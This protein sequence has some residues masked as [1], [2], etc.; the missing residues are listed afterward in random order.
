M[1]RENSKNGIRE[2]LLDD[3]SK[4]YEARVHRR[5]EPA[6]SKRFKT[7]AEAL[8]W[9]RSVDTSI[10]VGRPTLDRKV[11]LIRDVI[12]DYLRYRASSLK[13]LASNKV[14][15]YL[16]VREDL[17][18]ISVSKLTHIDIENYVTLLLEEPLKRDAKKSDKDG[19]K[20]TYKPATVRKFYYALK[21]AVEWHSKTYRYHVDEHL[22]SLEKGSVPD[23][24]AGKRER[25]LTTE[26][27]KK[28]YA[29]GL[30]R[31]NTFTEDDWR[32]IIGFALETAMREQEIVLAR[33]S[34]LSSDHRKLQV[35]KEHTKTRT[36]RVVLLSKRAREIVATQK[37]TCTE[38][39]SRIFHQFPNPESVCDAFARLTK[40]AK[41][42]DLKFHDLRH[43]AT[44]RLCESGKLNMMEVMEMTGHKN[45]TTF[46]GYLHL[47]KHDTSTVLD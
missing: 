8:K 46:Q 3:G 18:E 17:G 14:T 13:P 39:E 31:E 36:A 41:V 24:W 45:M 43:E 10:D 1:P 4:R 11:V 9:K 26:E 6:K 37:S 44:S 23:G 34:D 42:T 21:K 12:D 47:L 19:P 25:R 15:D 7:R 5:G 20:R 33:W 32:A 30:P 28:L 40:R 27:E 35:P 16:R 22:F 2:I 38:G 29:A